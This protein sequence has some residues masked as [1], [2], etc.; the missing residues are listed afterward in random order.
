[1]C[2]ECVEF[3]ELINLLAESDC[4]PD[5]I[6]LQELWQFP[7]YANFTLPGYNSLEYKLRNSST[8]GGGVG[9]YV[10]QSLKYNVLSAQSIFVN[11]IF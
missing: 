10:K 5:V 6:C 1:V 2:L 11:R 7:S 8:Q 9:I 3:S 4:A